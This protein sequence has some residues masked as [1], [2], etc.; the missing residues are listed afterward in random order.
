MAM[1]KL[2]ILLFPLV[3]LYSL[4]LRFRNKLFDWD[5]LCSHQI[6]FP[7]IGV[8]NLAIGGTGKS[9]VIE[10]LIS[11]FI[12]TKRIGVLSRGYGRQTRGVVFANPSS[13]AASIGD[14]PYQFY[15]K[16]NH[17]QVLVSEKRRLGVQKLVEQDS[18]INLLLLDDVMQHRYVKPDVMILTTTYHNPFFLDTLFPIGH[19]REPKSGYHRADLILVTKCPENLKEHELISFK[20]ELNLV[21]NQKVFFTKISYSSYVFN[22]VKK[23]ILSNLPDD[24]LLVTGIADPYPLIFFLKKIGLRFNHLSF[25]DHHAFSL[26]DVSRIN[27]SRKKGIVL[28]TEK[29]YTR[30]KDSLELDVLFYLPIEMKFLNLSME[31]EFIQC[32]DRSLS[33]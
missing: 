14:E 13:T 28:T 19:L 23:K 27:N 16:H 30:L 8:G 12:E 31:K 32:L 17:I 26:E 9:V 7:S 25:P 33:S 4:I 20:K 11:N 3:W 15:S 21:S 29:D 5:V 1:I 22:G 2:R 24:F 6:P 10:Y 18:Q